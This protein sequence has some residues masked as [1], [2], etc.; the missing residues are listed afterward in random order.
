MLADSDLDKQTL[1]LLTNGRD[2]QF[3]KL[4][5][6]D[7]PRYAFSKSFDLRNP[8]NELYVVLGILKRLAQIIS[9]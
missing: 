5:K 7:T 6:Q 9:E 1:G 3:I 2:F 4:T 8:G